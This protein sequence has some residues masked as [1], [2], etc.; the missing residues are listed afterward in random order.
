[1]HSVKSF[2]VLGGHGCRSVI[3]VRMDHVCVHARVR[4]RAACVHA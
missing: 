4:E 2:C 1:M 3:A